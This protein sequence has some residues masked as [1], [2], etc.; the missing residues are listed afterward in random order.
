MPSP[1]TA[2][3]QPI[4]CNSAASQ[5]SCRARPEWSS[6]S[7]T[8]RVFGASLIPGTLSLRG[9]HGDVRQMAVFV[10]VV[11]A[12]ADHEPV[13]DLEADVVRLEGDLL[14]P[15]LP[16]QDADADAGGAALLQLL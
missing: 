1:A 16:Q 5:T 2:T 3:G 6:E 11:Q 4:R 9:Q 8:K 14:P 13:G 15:D 7:M 10:V 12:V